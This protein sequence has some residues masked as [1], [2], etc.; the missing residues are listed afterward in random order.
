MKKSDIEEND[1]SKSQIIAKHRDII[2]RVVDGPHINIPDK[3]QGKEKLQ[4][5]IHVQAH[6]KSKSRR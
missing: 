3:S 5:M 1:Y 4:S 6:T 2:G